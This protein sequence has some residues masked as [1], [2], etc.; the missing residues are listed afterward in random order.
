MCLFL[1]AYAAVLPDSTSLLFLFG[2]RYSG[3]VKENVDACDWAKSLAQA[4]FAYTV[5]MDVQVVMCT[6]RKGNH[7]S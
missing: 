4:M 2:D 5:R 7:K 1:C 6:E 3:T